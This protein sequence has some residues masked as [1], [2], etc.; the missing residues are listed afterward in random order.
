M[1]GM[2]LTSVRYMYTHSTDS[3]PFDFQAYTDL[4]NSERL[5]LLAEGGLPSAIR[6]K[7]QAFTAKGFEPIPTPR[8]L[9]TAE[10]PEI[11]EQYA[12][13]A[14]NASAAGSTAWRCMPPT[15]I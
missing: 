6:P 10:I 2:F 14:R 9:E 13:A 11:V 8:E 7:G 1:T 5:G 15:A 3:L 4:I 12:Q